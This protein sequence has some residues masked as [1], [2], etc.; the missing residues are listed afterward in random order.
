M[1]LQGDGKEQVLKWLDYFMNMK[2]PYW[3]HNINIEDYSS[4]QKISFT[5]V[6]N[7]FN[8]FKD[9]CNLSKKMN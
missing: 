4:F 9:I 2:I 8:C 7:L 1:Q 5:D 3:S 6:N